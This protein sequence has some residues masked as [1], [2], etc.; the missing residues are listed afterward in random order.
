MQTKNTQGQT[1]SNNTVNCELAEK[2]GT[3]ILDIDVRLCTGLHELDTILKRQL[4][5]EKRQNPL[6]KRQ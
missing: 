6:Q 3:H 1:L 5:V 2:V 4:T